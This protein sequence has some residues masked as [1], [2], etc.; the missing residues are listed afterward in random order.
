MSA[1]KYGL[2]FG[3]IFWLSL[4]LGCWQAKEVMRG[5]C[6]ELSRSSVAIWTLFSICGKILVFLG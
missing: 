5:F 6:L 1:L 2:N 4:W 3:F